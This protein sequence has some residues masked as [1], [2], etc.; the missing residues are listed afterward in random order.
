LFKLWSFLTSIY[1]MKYVGLLCKKL[2]SL[3]WK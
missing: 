1:S 2:W 3:Y